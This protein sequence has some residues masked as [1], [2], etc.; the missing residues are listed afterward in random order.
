MIP[1]ALQLLLGNRFALCTIKC[2]TMWRALGDQVFRLTLPPPNLIWFNRHS[3]GVLVKASSGRPTADDDSLVVC[4]NEES[5]KLRRR[6]GTC[7]R[8]D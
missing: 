7:L 1:N 3:S 2:R 5:A 8:P 4:D 6:E